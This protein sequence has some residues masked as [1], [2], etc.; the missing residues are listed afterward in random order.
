[1][2][3][4]EAA[5]QTLQLLA[6]P[7]RVR[8]LALLEEQEL[9]VAEI[10]TVTELAQSRVSTHL[11]K[12]RDAGLLRDRRVGASAF[13]ALN[14]GNMPASARQMWAL[15]RSELKDA[16]LGGDKERCAEVLRARARQSAW[17][18]SVAGQMERHYSPGRTWEATARALFG[19]MQ[20]GDVLD[21]GC[22]DGALAQM[23]APR[24]K[25]VTCID[26]NPKM[27][28]AALARFGKSKNVHVRLADVHAL[29]FR[30]RSFDQV[31]LFNILTQAETPALVIAE[32]AR[33]LRVGGALTV[34]TLAPHDHLALTATYHDVH[35]GFSPQQLRRLLG[36]ASLEIDACDV[37]CREK[38]A[39]HFEVVTAFARKAH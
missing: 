1:V 15:V 21:A 26:R 11:G 17:P 38:R 14:T 32:A 9:T 28:D 34:V 5:T 23:L 39:P 35:A 6:D 2:T 4:L 29:P 20:L 24:A 36:K 37:V 19:L 3:T 7:T 27:V 16:V 18:S 25:S 12:L 30:D 13:Y 22:G 8:L 31:M 10:V 33:V